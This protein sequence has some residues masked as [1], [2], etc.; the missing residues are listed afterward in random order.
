[1]REGGTLDKAL[2]DTGL[3]SLAV[4]SQALG[5]LGSGTAPGGSEAP[6]CLLCIRPPG[7][8]QQ[9]SSREAGRNVRACKASHCRREEAVQAAR[10]RG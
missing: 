8:R 4:T 7:Q 1:M 5:L 2:Q 3:G 10:R 9:S 6:P